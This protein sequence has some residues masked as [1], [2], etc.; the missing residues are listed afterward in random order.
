MVVARHGATAWNAESRIMGVRPIPLS[1]VGRV[2][3]RALAAALVGHFRPS[4]CVTSPVLR[5][6]QTADILLDGL[7]VSPPRRT[8]PGFSEFVMGAWEG[9]TLGELR[10]LD[11]WQRYLNTPDQ[12]RFP[13]GETLAEIQSRAVGALNEIV[14]EARGS[15]LVVTHAGIARLLALAALGAPLSSYHRTGVGTATFAQLRLVPGRPP[16]LRALGAGQAPVVV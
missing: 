4:H 10:S 14:A 16:Q 5:A 11:A 1:D 2:E 9:Q 7:G 12:I 6:V 8:H 3:A 13:D 15:V